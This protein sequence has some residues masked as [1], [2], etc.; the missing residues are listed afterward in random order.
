MHHGGVAPTPF[1]SRSLALAAGTYL[2][3]VMQWMGLECLEM[4]VGWR[5]GWRYGGW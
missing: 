5:D 2:I 4:C 3:L 1:P